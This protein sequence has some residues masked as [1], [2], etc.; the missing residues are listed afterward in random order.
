MKLEYIVKKNNYINVKQILKEEFNMSDRL[1]LKLKHAKNIKLNGEITYVNKEVLPND[2]LEVFIDFV[3][4]CSNIVPTKMDLDIIYEDDCMLVINKPAGLAVH[5]SILH[6]DNSLANGVKFYFNEI[7][8]KKKIRPVN[9]L[10][11]DTSR[12]CYFCKKRV[13]TRMF[14]KTNE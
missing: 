2:K 14:S 9:R 4:E 12:Y 5:P 11:K 1:I 10:D 3:E 6:Y 8:L 13:Y 7:G